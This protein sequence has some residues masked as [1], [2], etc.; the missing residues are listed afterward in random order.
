MLVDADAFRE[1]GGFDETMRSAR[2]S[3]WSGGSPRSAGSGTCPTCGSVIARGQPVRGAR[4]ARVYGTSAADLGRRHPGRFGTSTC[5][6]GRSGPG[7]WRSRCTRWWV[8]PPPPLTAAIAPWGMRDLRRGT[9]D[10]W[11]RRAT[12]G[13]A[14]AL[15]RWLIRPMLPAT[16][17]AG[18]LS[19]RMGRRLLVA[20]AAGLG[21]LVVLDVRAAEGWRRDG[22]RCRRD[23]GRV[24][25]R[26]DAGRRGL[27]HRCLAGRFRPSHPGTG[28]AEVRDLPA[29][30]RLR[31]PTAEGSD[32][33]SPTG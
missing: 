2:T 8:L 13:P 19:P 6:S 20:A 30:L 9:P 1:V 16:V 22:R 33:P 14:A 26:Q 5:R 29:W 21:Y 7:C 31:R 4:P 23:G 10:N 17:I 3:T 18:M 12:C 15:G 28:A 25:G 11:P 32:R 24:A 27:Q